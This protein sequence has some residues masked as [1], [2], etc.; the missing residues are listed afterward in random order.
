M[1]ITYTLIHYINIP[2]NFEIT[3]IPES[4]KLQV[5]EFGSFEYT[6]T[7]ENQ[8]ISITYNFELKHASVSPANYK[9]LK[10]FFDI[11]VEK[12]GALVT[13]KRKV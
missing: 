8:K 10:D 9:K 2:A 1:L 5:D 6:I 4:Q 12:T 13:L 11:L 7:A 3:G